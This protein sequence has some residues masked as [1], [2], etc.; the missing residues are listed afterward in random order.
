[1]REMAK[2][3]VLFLGERTP[4]QVNPWRIKSQAVVQKTKPDE[5]PQVRQFR[6]GTAGVRRV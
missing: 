6:P 1:V 5:A 3:K 2:K 4:Q